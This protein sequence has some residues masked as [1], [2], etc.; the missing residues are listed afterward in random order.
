MTTQFSFFFREKKETPLF[1]S[2]R[3]VLMHLLNQVFYLKKNQKELCMCGSEL[4]LIPIFLHCSLPLPTHFRRYHF[5]GLCSNCLTIE[6]L[7]ELYFFSP[8]YKFFMNGPRDILHLFN[9]AKEIQAQIDSTTADFIN[10]MKL[11]F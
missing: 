4:G 5:G 8:L 10:L 7:D 11:H 2:F 3:Q 6:R 1:L 9:Y